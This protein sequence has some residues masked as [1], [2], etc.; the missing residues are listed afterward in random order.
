[1]KTITFHYDFLSPFAY[2]AFEHLPQALAGLSFHV[3]YRPVLLGALLR[4]HGLL[5][6]A[7]VP[8]K[9]EATYRHAL[10]LGH[11]HQVPF[12]LPS[13]HPFN[14]LPHLRLA[15][16]TTEG[17][18]TN[19][20]VTETIFRDIWR[21]RR[22]SIGPGAAGRPGHAPAA[23]ARARQRRGE[24]PPAREHRRR[25]RGR[26]LRHADPG[27]GR[28]ALLGLRRAARAARLAGGRPVVR[29]RRLA[30]GRRPPGLVAPGKVL[31]RLPSAEE[32]VF[33]ILKLRPWV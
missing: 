11:A 9:R 14:P 23:G 17:G 4:A 13:L 26:H 10:W 22:R 16:A 12:D 28:P 30:H 32:A 33:Y 18:D 27:S 24:G 20:F 6:P 29:R 1:M 21:R 7:E 25:S 2:L 3:R 19:R 8:H 5:G 15:L 31:G